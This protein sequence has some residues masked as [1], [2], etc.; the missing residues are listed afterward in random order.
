[1]SYGKVSSRERPG[2]NGNFNGSVNVET[3][4]DMMVITVKKRPCKLYPN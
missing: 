4:P 2:H 3:Q 1:M